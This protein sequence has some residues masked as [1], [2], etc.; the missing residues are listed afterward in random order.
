MALNASNLPRWL[1]NWGDGSWAE[2]RAVLGT[3]VARKRK[4]F[5]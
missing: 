3:I 1:M 2:E 5:V 4:Q